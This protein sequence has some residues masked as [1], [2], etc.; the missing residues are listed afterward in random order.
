MPFPLAHPAAILPLRRF[1]PRY[2]SLAGL[3]LGSIVPDL[4]YVPDDLNRFPD[5]VLFLLGPTARTSKYVMNNW[6][7]STFSHSLPG[8]VFFCLPVGILLLALFFMLRRP[9]TAMLP[10]P[11]RE[12]LLPL[13]ETRRESLLACGISL[14]LGILLH[15]GWDSFTHDHGWF[16]RHISSLRTPLFDLQGHQIQ[17]VTIIWFLSST[18]GIAV[19]LITYVHFLHSRQLPLWNFARTEIRFYRFWAIVLLVP[20]LV[21]V[22]CTVHF[23]RIESSWGDVSYVFHVFSEYYLT[24]LGL[25]LIAIGA[26]VKWKMTKVRDGGIL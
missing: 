12:A 26:A 23:T 7:W 13:C 21:A 14:L 6:E 19:L 16:V 22:P 3:L 1:C 4:A 18:G 9:L 15:L 11:H 24:T 25:S 20:V 10:N 5:T 17:P 2:L 8:V